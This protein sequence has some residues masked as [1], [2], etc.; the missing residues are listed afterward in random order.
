M[1][2]QVRIVPPTPGEGDEKTPAMMATLP[3]SLTSLSDTPTLLEITSQ[4]P[5][6]PRLNVASA[7][8]A[9]L[10]DSCPSSPD[11]VPAVIARP[12]QMNEAA[13]RRMSW[14][15]QT[16][17]EAIL[18]SLPAEQRRVIQG[19]TDLKQLIVP[20]FQ[21]WE[22]FRST[23]G[24][25]GKTKKLAKSMSEKMRASFSMSEVSEK[26]W[27][28]KLSAEK[29]D[30]SWR[31]FKDLVMGLLEHVMLVDK[32]LNSLNNCMV[33]VLFYYFANNS[34]LRLYRRFPG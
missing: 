11:D 16:A 25:A 20:M 24:R 9:C 14:I 7:T 28:R 15:L 27:S 17:M 34:L 18:P 1:D 23:E 22:Q 32:V 12:E 29:E 26:F 21:S 33:H 13:V 5:V 3:R 8:S 30:V 4:R 2:I 10:T 6:L 31:G 19:T